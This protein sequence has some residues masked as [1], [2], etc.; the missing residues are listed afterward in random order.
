MSTTRD[1]L[2]YL[3]QKIDIAP[4][5]SEEEYQAAALLESLMQSHGLETRLQDFEAPGA[6]RL[7]Y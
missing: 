3:S 1:Y 7:A 6:G 2:E 4:V 5:N